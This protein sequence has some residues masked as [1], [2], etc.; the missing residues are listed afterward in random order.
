MKSTLHYSLLQSIP[1]Q[2]Q[3]ELKKAETF[4]PVR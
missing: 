1:D 4:L 3:K 2:L